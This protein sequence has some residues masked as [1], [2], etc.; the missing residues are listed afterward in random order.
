[1]QVSN[2]SR[3]RCSLVDHIAT[4]ASYVSEDMGSLL[5]GIEVLPEV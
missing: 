1:M 3:R 5:T 2:S 4:I